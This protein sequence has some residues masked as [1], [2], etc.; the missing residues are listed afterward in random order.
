MR[1]STAAAR[2]DALTAVIAGFTLLRLV[3]AAATPLLPQEAYYWVWSRHLAASYFDH[4]PLM[5][6]SIALTTALFGST[7]LGIKSAAVLWGL[8]WNLLWARLVIDLFGD[9]RLAWRTLLALNLTVLYQVHALGAAP[10][11]PLIF[12]WVGTIWAVWRACRRDQT[13]WWLLAG[14][15]AGLALLGKYSAVLLGPVVLGFLLM[16]P[17]HRVQLRRPGPWLAAAVAALLFTPVLLWNAQHGWVSFAFQSTRRIGQMAGLRPQHLLGLAATQ[18]LLVTPFLFALALAAF[19]RGL[20]DALARRPDERRLLLWVS[21]AVP[22]LLFGTVA[23]RAPVRINWLAPA[24]WSL[25]VLAAA[26]LPAD[27]PLPR[28][29]RIGLASSAVM[30]LLVLV[31]FTVPNL[32]LPHNLNSWSAWHETAQQV[33]REQ[34]ALQARGERS[35]VFGPNY[36]VASLLRFHL[37]G[38]PRTYAQDIYGAPAL[39]YDYL[40]P[41]GDLR[42]ATGILVLADQDQA[43]LDL[44]RLAPY[45]ASVEPAQQLQTGAFGR[46]ARRTEIWLCRGYRGHP[47]V[48]ATNPAPPR[49]DAAQAD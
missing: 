15:M 33:A 47:R 42:G 32:P 22:L 11:A 12:G 34:Q 19:G 1:E 36:K 5:S 18:A 49:D 13:R 46:S 14:A 38:K 28:G 8:G 30:L 2:P 40:P 48:H 45:C 26:R 9:R 39:Q 27:T 4:P 3:L 31:V 20:R 21:A 44:T 29:W 35:F 6:W 23:L 16:S 24:W 10:D 41:A 7:A 43:Q 17:A 25:I 37:P